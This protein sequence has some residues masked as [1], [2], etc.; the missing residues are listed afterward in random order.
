MTTTIVLPKL[1]CGAEPHAIDPSVGGYY[2]STV[3][4]NHFS[5]AGMFVGCNEGKILYFPAFTLN[6]KFENFRKQAAHAG[7]TVVLK[8]SV[9]ATGTTLSVVDKTT[10]HSKKLTGAGHTSTLNPWAADTGWVNK[11]EGGLEPVP[12]FG[13]IAFAHT[14]LDGAPFGNAAGL[15]QYDRYRHSTLEIS[16]SAFQ[17]N[18]ETFSTVFHHS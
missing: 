2:G 9:Q 7:D 10:K 6:G 11:S 8:A 3:N 5:D 1:K 15:V 18:Q 13:K 17:G 14:L 16:T 4:P 12:N